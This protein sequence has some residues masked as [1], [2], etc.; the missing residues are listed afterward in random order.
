MLLNGMNTRKK[1][2]IY[3]NTN[4]KMAKK[5]GLI[6]SAF[7]KLKNLKLLE[8]YYSSHCSNRNHQLEHLHGMLTALRALL[9]T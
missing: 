4:E 1:N 5:A 9:V 6:A 7:T 2:A 3:D 8:L